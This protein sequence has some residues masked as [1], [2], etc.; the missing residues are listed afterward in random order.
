[1][2]QEK[3]WDYFQGEAV[4][5]FDGNAT[6]L[7]FLA[8]QL[9]P[10]DKRVLNIGVG[11]GFLEKTLR[12]E[13]RAEVYSLDPSEGAV[14][15]L[16]GAAGMDAGHAR[17]GYSQAM[18][19]PDGAFDVVIMS[20]VIEHLDDTVID[21]TFHEVSRVLAPHGRYLG[22]VP[23][24][25]KLENSRVACPHCGE[26]FHRWGHV[27]SFSRERLADLL[28][29]EFDRVAV[30]HVYFGNWQTL[31]WKGRLKWMLKKFLQWAGSGGS[32]ANLYF[33]AARRP[34]R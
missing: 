26:V 33:E 12:A 3:I 18:P 20:E 14:E 17:V 19:F 1:M 25:E 2:Q 21:A 30:R 23:A 15:R 4:D 34:G 32:G 31:N 16:R 27:Q 5:S 6:R 24:D 11:N 9:R 29:R 7:R 8:R 13:S 22:T 10:A 28:R